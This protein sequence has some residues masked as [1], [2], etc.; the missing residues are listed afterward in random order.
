MFITHIPNPEIQDEL[1]EALKRRIGEYEVENS[2][3]F[4]EKDRAFMERKIIG[5]RCVLTLDILAD[6]QIDECLRYRKISEDQE[7]LRADAHQQQ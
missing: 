6:D 2:V 1:I 7:R 4:T 3:T 5:P